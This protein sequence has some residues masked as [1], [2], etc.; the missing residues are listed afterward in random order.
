MRRTV[1][2]CTRHT[3][4]VSEYPQPTKKPF[5]RQYD[6]SEINSDI[7]D[8]MA[9]GPPVF[10]GLCRMAQRHLRRGVLFQF[11]VFAILGSHFFDLH[12]LSKGPKMAPILSPSVSR[13]ATPSVPRLFKRPPLISSPFSTSVPSSPSSPSFFRCGRSTYTPSLFN[14]ISL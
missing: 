1:W 6:S 7:K 8:P 10:G 14:S 2:G 13:M 11:R 9:D 3:W 5:T 12:P 4:G